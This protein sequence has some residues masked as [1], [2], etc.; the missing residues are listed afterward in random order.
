M[1]NKKKI[2]LYLD[3]PTFQEIKDFKDIDGYTFNP[4]LY[5]KLKAENYIEFTKKLI[6]KT[7]NKPISIE[8]IADDDEN[9]IRQGEKISKLGNSIYVKIP[10]IF[11]SGQS[12]KKTIKSLVEKNIK[13]NITAIFEISQVKEILLI[14]K[15]SKAILSIFSGRIFDIGLDAVKV[16]GEMA[17]YIHENSNCKVLWASSRMSYDYILAQKCG[18]DIITM[19]PN[20]AKKIA[21]FGKSSLEYSKDTVKGFFDDA[22]SSGFVL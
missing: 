16:F 2:E 19:Q 15:D 3:G 11:T 5:K 14:L 9:C 13:L 20:L 18:A 17:K 22:K 10:V 21:L 7:N 1:S 4:S 6:D 8:V 12:S